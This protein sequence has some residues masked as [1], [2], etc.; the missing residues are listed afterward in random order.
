MVGVKKGAGYYGN[1]YEGPNLDQ[2]IKDDFLEG[3]ISKLRSKVWVGI[4]QVQE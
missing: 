3:V 4:S 2:E 1:P